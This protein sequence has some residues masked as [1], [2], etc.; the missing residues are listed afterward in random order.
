MLRVREGHPITV[1]GDRGNMGKAIAEI[2]SVLN[3]SNFSFFYL[4]NFFLQNFINLMDKLKLTI[5]A[6]DMVR[7][8]S[9][10]KES[11]EY[12]ISSF[13]QMFGNYQMLL[14]E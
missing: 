7:L 3:N 10:E 2:V 8:M 12:N 4:M 14:I 9:R 13:K 6:N 1:R 11:I 5:R